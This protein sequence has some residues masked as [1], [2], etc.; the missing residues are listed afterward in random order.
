MSVSRQ[1]VWCTGRA[2]VFGVLVALST[3]SWS[4]VGVGQPPAPEQ[5][6]EAPKDA[7]GRDT[8][9]GAVLSFLTASRKGN[10]GAVAALYLNTPLRGEDGEELA[11]QLAVVLDRK[12]P[13]RINEISDKPEGSLPDPL[14]PDEDVIGTI[15]SAQGD[16]DIR[17]ERID[18]GKVGK[19]WLFSRKTL[20]AIPDLYA[21]IKT[22][23]IEEFLPE[24]LLKRL[25]NIPCFEWFAVF[26]G[27]PCL[28][29]LT[30]LLDRLLSVGLGS[31]RRRLRH[32]KDLQ[33]PRILLPPLRLLVLAGI[34]RGLLSR[35]G[36]P[37]LARQFWSTTALVI[38][39]CACTW[40]LILLNGWGE[41]YLVGRHPRLSGSAAVI[42]LF[43]RVVDALI[44]FAAL[45]F[46]LYHFGVNPTAALAGLGVGGIAVALAAQKT[47]EN[48]IAGISLIADQAVHVGDFLKVGDMVGTVEEV[49]LRSTRIRT[50]ERTVLCIPN[51]QISTLTLETISLRDK[52]WFH[53][54]L[55]LR[56]ETTADQMRTVTTEIHKLLTG[57]PRIDTTS[58]RVRFLG[59][60]PSSLSV[61][62]FAYLFAVDWSHFLELQEELLLKVIEIIQQAGAEIAFPSQTTYLAADSADQ[63]ARSVVQ[64]KQSHRSEPLETGSRVRN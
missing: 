12:L 13:A 1:R 30:G 33:N 2:I 53:P 35:I 9:R 41:R 48:L 60:G 39:I 38:T 63:L 26:I 34:I 31:L 40:L 61:E 55:G 7:L 20:D 44:L 50:L 22:P 32:R 27:M 17:M 24:F 19:V 5:K 46:T 11:R 8:P 21:E 59:I 37:L 23:P 52:F 42:R 64:Q 28:Y 54:I 51:G 29:L 43:R 18:R 4:Q 49:G 57:H 15:S 3:V 36:L 16:I 14:H 25:W 47:L 56:F 62:L 58:V 45:L 6:P 10:L